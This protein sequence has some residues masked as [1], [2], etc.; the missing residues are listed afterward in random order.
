MEDV[1]RSGNGLVLG[2]KGVGATKWLHAEITGEFRLKILHANG[3]LRSLNLSS[4]AGTGYYKALWQVG[5][6][7]R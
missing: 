3:T 6:P 7:L 2:N 1:A 4:A 5:L